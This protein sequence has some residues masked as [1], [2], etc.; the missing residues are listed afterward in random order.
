MLL[1]LVARRFFLDQRRGANL[2]EQ[3][4]LELQ[5]DAFSC[6]SLLAFANRAEYIFKFI[7]PEQQPSEQTKLT[8]FF[9][10]LKK[11]RLLQRHVDRI[12]DARE[13]SRVR[14]GRTGDW[15]FPN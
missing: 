7:P 6:Q 12:K 14:T 10:R 3:A 15:L 11:C 5:L 2:T 4:L 13:V 8:W 1:Q 9:G